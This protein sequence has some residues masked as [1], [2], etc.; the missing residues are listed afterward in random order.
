MKISKQ[1]IEK[2]HRNE[3]S[4]EESEAVEAWVFSGESNEALQLPLGEDKAQHKAALWDEIEKILPEESA[5]PTSTKRLF[6]KNPFWSGAIAATLFIAV[7]GATG[8]YL[9]TVKS[10][11][12]MPLIVNNS[13]SM[14]VK[15]IDASA[16]QISVGTNTSTKI[17]NT[18]GV[19]DL[20]GSLLISPKEDMELIFEGSSEKMIFKAGQTYIILKGENGIDKVIVV[21]EKNIMD[22]P[23]VLQKQIINE[24]QI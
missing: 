14:H 10:A 8:Y 9:S 6:Y 19:I 12:D 23:P 7:L 1:L 2:Y 11:R 17:N 21:N 22:L 5:A 24:F 18:T 13:S 3:C 15:H 20:S 4:T 16:Y